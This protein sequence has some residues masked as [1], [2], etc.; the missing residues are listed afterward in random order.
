VTYQLLPELQTVLGA[1]YVELAPLLK[2]PNCFTS[3]VS[4]TGCMDEFQTLTGCCNAACT[5]ALGQVRA[6]PCNC[7]RFKGTRLVRRLC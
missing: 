6:A 3:L 5:V 2:T 7:A 4:T 1:A